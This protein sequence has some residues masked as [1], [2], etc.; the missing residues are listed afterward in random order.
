MERQR[1][2]PSLGDLFSRLAS[3]TSNLVRQ[4]VAL[5]RTELAQ[6]ASEVGRDAAM[7]GAGGAVAYAGFLALLGALIIGLGR[8]M[9]LWLAAVLVGVVVLALG[10]VLVQRG[11]TALRQANLVPQQTIE[12]LKEDAQWIKDQTK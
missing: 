10:A 12:T 8:V 1:D 3:D 4:E 11:L 6:K 9:P 5:A 2:E 7:L